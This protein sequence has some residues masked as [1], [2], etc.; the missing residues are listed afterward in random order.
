MMAITFAW[1]SI[2][3]I[4]FSNSLIKAKISRFQHHIERVT[5][6]VLIALGIKVAMSSQK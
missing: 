5:G 6:A 1:F 2:V 3:S 4:L